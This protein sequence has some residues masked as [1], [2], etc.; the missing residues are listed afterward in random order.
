[1]DTTVT[2]I[3]DSLAGSKSPEGS[4]AIEVAEVIEIHCEAADDVAVSSLLRH[5]CQQSSAK[6]KVAASVPEPVQASSQNGPVGRQ[7]LASSM[8]PMH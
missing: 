3:F 2:K 1:M 4:N 8:F 6:L 7:L 5:H